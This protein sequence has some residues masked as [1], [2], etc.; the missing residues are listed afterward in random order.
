VLSYA[1]EPFGVKPKDLG[2]E[3][4]QFAIAQHYDAIVRRYLDLLENPERCGK[5][6]RKHG[7]IVAN[8]AWNDM[9][10][11]L[12][13]GQEF[14]ESA[15][16]ALNAENRPAHAMVGHFK[17]AEPAAMA[18]AIDLADDPLALEM[19][20]R[21]LFHR[22]NEFVA[23]NPM[24]VHIPTGDFDVS[25]A[26]ARSQHTHQRLAFG[27]ARHRNFRHPRFTV[28]HKRP[29]KEFSSTKAIV[30]TIAHRREN[31]SRRATP[32]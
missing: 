26:H 16:P 7:H 29:H 25:V 19:G 12:G 21:T 2:A 5:R 20:I 28:K 3:L 14:G 24:E 27:R 6:F 30:D 18:N 17:A 13:Q 23:R 1:N 11:F 9:E 32:R 15:L 10:V 22:S 4:P 31:E 8:R